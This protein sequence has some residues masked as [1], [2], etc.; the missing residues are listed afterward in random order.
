GRWDE[1]RVAAMEA[2]AM[3]EEMQGDRAASGI[4]FTLAYLCA[5]DGQWA[6]A[7]QRLSRLRHFFGATRDERRL[8]E[9]E[10]IAAHPDFSH[11]RF[12]EARRQASLILNAGLSP[13]ITEA[14]ALILDE[15]DWIEKRDASLRSTGRSGNVELTDRHR[16][17]R[18][19]RGAEETIANPFI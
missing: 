17:M 10:L 5:D 6:H 9:L 12:V 7:A 4:L 14:A 2:L 13:Q 15:I 16:L 3:V 18:A 19:R 11:R 8:L 1:T